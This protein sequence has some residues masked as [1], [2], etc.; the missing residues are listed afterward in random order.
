MLSAVVWWQAFRG[1]I[2]WCIAVY[3]FDSSGKPLSIDLYLIPNMLTL[4]LIGGV[5]LIHYSESM[6]LMPM[7]LIGWKNFV[8]LNPYI[9][10]I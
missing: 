3:V 6:L 9:S 8:D 4:S 7:S 1:G 2:C 5:I 10:I